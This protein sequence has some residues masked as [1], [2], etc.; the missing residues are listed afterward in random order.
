MQQ[1]QEYQVLLKEKFCAIIILYHTFGDLPVTS[2]ITILCK[3]LLIL[4]GFR[5]AVFTRMLTGL[6]EVME[7]TFQR[8]VAPPPIVLRK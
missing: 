2:Q 8:P 6:S 3:A 7:V 5:E 1:L 4:E